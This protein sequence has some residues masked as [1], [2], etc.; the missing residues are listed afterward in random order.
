MCVIIEFRG[1]SIENQGDLK[2][3]T[4]LAALPTLPRGSG[5]VSDEEDD[6]CLCGID[7]EEVARRIGVYC[8]RDPFGYVFQEIDRS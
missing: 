7:A 3:V 6:H 2:R 4:G 8:E 5:N 1:K